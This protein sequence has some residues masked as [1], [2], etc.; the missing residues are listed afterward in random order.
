MSDSNAVFK[1]RC[2]DAKGLVAAITNFFYETGLNILNCQ[3][4]TDTMTGQYFMRLK[5]DLTDLPCSK[6]ELERRLVKRGNNTPEEIKGRLAAAEREFAFRDQFDHVVVNDEVER[7]VDE[8]AQLID[9]EK[10]KL[11]TEQKNLK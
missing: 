3:Q 5:L 2:M 4:Y 6:K 10:R 11:K 8:I 9:E 7:A 1:I